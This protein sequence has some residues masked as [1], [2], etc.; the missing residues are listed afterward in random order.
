MTMSSDPGELTELQ[1]MLA[2]KRHEQ[3]PT[4]FFR[5]LSGSVI[6]R[7]Q[8]DEPPH[9]QTWRQRVGLDFDAKPV[10]VCATGVGVCG[11]LLLG[12]I[13]SQHIEP[14]A[15]EAPQAGP[16]RPSFVPLPAP[17]P[18]PASPAHIVPSEKTLTRNAADDPV[19]VRESSPLRSLPPPGGNVQPVV[20]SSG[21]SN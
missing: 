9:E 1:K 11:L 8:T 7:L 4:Q 12:L 18:A 17:T 16:A 13:S 15:Q 6:E 21:K 10:L 5:S 14:P 20:N 19:I 2:L 3:P